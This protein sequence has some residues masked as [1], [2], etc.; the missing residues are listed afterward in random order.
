M[1]LK[2]KLV[3][4]SPSGWLV[5]GGW[6][7]VDE[8]EINAISTQIELVVEVEAELGKMDDRILETS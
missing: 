7:W 5:G 1:E 4:T 8:N 6:W 2:L 3:T